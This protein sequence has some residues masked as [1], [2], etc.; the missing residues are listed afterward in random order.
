MGIYDKYKKIVLPLTSVKTQVTTALPGV[1]GRTVTTGLGNEGIDLAIWINEKLEDNTIT[2]PGLAELIQLTGLPEGSSTLGSFNGNIIP[3]NS[4]IKQ[5]LQILE[6]AVMGAGGGTG[7]NGIYT[8][9]GDIAS[10]V[11]ANVTDSFSINTGASDFVK[12]GDINGVLSNNFSSINGIG[13]E[14]NT[15]GYARLGQVFSQTGYA[16]SLS[17]SKEELA[18]T[19]DYNNYLTFTS[20]EF[21]VLKTDKTQFTIWGAYTNFKGLAY[22]SDY[23]NNFIAR[24][25]VDKAY[26][27]SKVQIVADGNK[28]DITLS[29]NGSVWLI[30]NGVVTYNKLQ[31]V[32]GSRLLGRYDSTTGTIQEIELGT[33]LAFVNNTLV[34]TGGS[35][36]I[37]LTTNNSS[38][39]A[40]LNSGILNIPNYSLT[41]LGGVPTS[42]T[43]TINGET[44]DLSQNRSWNITSMIYPSAG[45]PIS[46]GT[47]WGTSITNNST[48]WNTA[49][50]WGN[51]ATQGYLTSVN[52]N[53]LTDVTIGTL[54][55]GQILQ[56]NGTTSQWENV[57]VTIGSGDMQKSVYDIDNDGIVDYAETISVDVR[58]NSSTDIL[59]RGT[60]VYLSGSTG[61]R[62]NAVK[63]QANAEVTSSGTFGVVINDI[64]PNSDGLVAAMGSL[65]NL[66]TRTAA[67]GNPNPFTSDTLVDGDIL[68]LDPN[69]AGYVTK[70][71]PSAPNHAVFIGIVARTSPTNGSI[72]YKI[73][74]GYEIDE[75]HNVKITAPLD[76]NQ[77]LRYNSSNSLWENKTLNF[78][79]PLTLTTIGTSG[80]ATL[81]GDGT[82]NIP[83]YST[84]PGGSNT[85]V[86]FNNSGAFGGSSKFTWNGTN[87]KLSDVTVAS[88]SIAFNSSESG[89]FGTNQTTVYINNI[90][91]Y[92]SPSEY[93]S[94][95]VFNSYNNANLYGS[96]PLT[97]NSVYA[98]SSNTFL[99]NEIRLDGSV[100]ITNI[101]TSVSTASGLVGVTISNSLFKTSLD[102]S[103]LSLSS[104]G[105][106]S[107]VIKTLNDLTDVVTPSPT[108]GQF[109][110]Y[111]GTN[112]V[113]QSL[114]A[115][116]YSTNSAAVEVS[117]VTG[118]EK[119]SLY[120]IDGNK[121]I[122]VSNNGVE[123]QDR[124]VIGSATF[125]VGA[126]LTLDSNSK[127]LLLPRLTTT[128]ITTNLNS[129]TD[130]MILYDSTTQTF[131]GR[132]NGAWGSLGSGGGGTPA[133][134][135][136][137]IQFNNAGAF[138]AS[139]KLAWDNSTS[140][141]LNIGA[142]SSPTGA[143]NVKGTGNLNTTVNLRLTDSGDT[144]LLKVL[145]NGSTNIG[146]GFNWDNTNGRLG[147]NASSPAV[148]LDVVGSMNIG[149]NFSMT[150]NT[151]FSVIGSQSNRRITNNTGALVSNQVG[152]F[153]GTVD[154]AGSHGFTNG[155]ALI[156]NLE[157][158]NTGSS[159][160]ISGARVTLNNL[161]TASLDAGYGVWSRIDNSSP[162]TVPNMR[163]YLADYVNQT[164]SSVVTN[165][166]LFD[167]NLRTNN[168]VITN[169]YGIYVGDITK[170]T[171]TNTPFSFYASDPNAF[172]YFAG[173]TSI[174]TTT[175]SARLHV[176]GEN[177]L[178]TSS[179]LLVQ[180]NATVPVNLLD[181]R[182]NGAILIGKNSVT[183]TQ[184]TA[185][186][187]ADGSDTNIGIAI[188]PKGNGAIT[189]AIP[190]GGTIG[191]NA[192]GSNAIDLQTSR[193][194]ATQVASGTGSIVIGQNNTGSGGN[195]IAIGINNNSSSSSI[196]IGSGNGSSATWSVSIGSG[197]A[198]SANY[199]TALGRS[200]R[201]TLYG[202][203]SKASGNFASLG[204]CQTSQ[205]SS[206][207]SITGT[208]AAE[209]TLDGAN[210]GTSNRLTL[211]LIGATNGRLWNAII[212]LS[213]ICQ[214]A[215]GSVTV[216][217][218]F[219]GTYNL[220][221]KRI[222]N[223]TSLVG[224][225]QNMITAQADT[226]M[227]SSVVTI[228][229]DDTTNNE[230][231]KIEFTPPSGADAN[232]VIRV[233]ATVY[234]TE[235][236]Y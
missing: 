87:L 31:N 152:Y 62:P 32:T 187:A 23:S 168:G 78:Q 222:A 178:S 169:T 151:P 67:N 224:T 160:T 38:G 221:I 33:G 98:N 179:A 26:V 236:G 27:D 235:V 73:Q 77:V 58:N 142:P 121:T 132:A 119:A 104:S 192:R 101:P 6:T 158:R 107:G 79:A 153:S 191:G 17:I 154:L 24:S 29:N 117:S 171:Q 9:S 139:S 16:P 108:T 196:A 198:A 54:N 173:N 70:T 127:G 176:R 204:D 63:A 177:D 214:T 203:L 71:K 182:N 56:Y 49:F 37:L 85:E 200:S 5:A 175:P 74:N 123:I 215:G 232:T 210:P 162:N 69:T 84:T 218:S 53:A 140:Y 95:L 82:L 18:L 1:I 188:V 105:V 113:N 120:S 137:E 141:K 134:N 46:T 219:I 186:I 20:T 144:E 47:G 61:N 28:G 106:L 116:T 40:T 21:P 193:T 130:G 207:R 81:A 39:P 206:F 209:L 35:G 190:D 125:D 234:L 30:N 229:A 10:N 161:S 146:T 91:A 124:A 195:A 45:I 97:I 110:R 170:G 148:T 76:N 64:G 80:T 3:D 197:N 167:A 216:G 19:H 205:L 7:L 138:A 4:T 86:Q 99:R 189:A 42:R 114:T 13:L 211:N 15:Q 52:L 59:R 155:G 75:L 48:N 14:I 159:N 233:V 51:H 36:G 165:L 128:Q 136:G 89:S 208:A 143:L 149:G 100:T 157:N 111:N 43:I 129:A 194:I 90:T 164:A 34:S 115:L 11:I 112:W 126:L 227:S 41:G 68:W 150:T 180:N 163:T 231:L 60:I 202:Q 44:Y 83:N 72:V 183:T 199:S 25:L 92:N 118:A 122:A 57:S 66:D 96:T 131:K 166:Y 145:D 22:K 217:E 185:S 201:S 181:I 230:C 226:N 135:T 213:A 225:V 50:G 65:H 94:S 102:A 156:F 174:G 223:T 212:Q 133:G 2:I 55:N 184:N 103:T 147:L 109:L 88:P 172:N 8:G 220:G 12:I 93:Q 228:T